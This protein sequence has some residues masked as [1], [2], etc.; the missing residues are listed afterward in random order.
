MSF[1]LFAQGLYKA[2]MFSSFDAAKR[3]LTKQRPDGMPAPLSKLELFASGGFAGAV[4]SFVVTPVELVRNRLMV[5]YKNAGPAV[6][7]G[8]VD[9]VQQ[10]LR[11]TGITG[12]WKGQVSTLCRDVPGVGSWYFGNAIANEYFANK[13][14]SSPK[15]P[16]SIV[17]GAFAGICFWLVALPLDTVKTIVQTNTSG[18]SSLQLISE[19]YAQE[20]IRG[21]YRGMG[22]ALL[23]GIP[24][25]ATTFTA[26]DMV[27]AWLQE[28]SKTV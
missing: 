14:P 10:I 1:P 26:Y 4:N 18:R 21:F 9:A 7:R 3:F 12:L 19:R 20:G 28:S 8:P 17:S 15:A 2:V 6:Y 16:R 25:A 11:T 5:Q 27:S 22:V 13:Y 24:A 23:R